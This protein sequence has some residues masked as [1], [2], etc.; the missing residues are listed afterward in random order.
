MAGMGEAR[1]C[2]AGWAGR[3]VGGGWSRGFLGRLTSQIE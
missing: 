3:V 1:D 2:W